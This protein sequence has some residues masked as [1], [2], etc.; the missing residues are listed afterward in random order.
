MNGF[1]ESSVIQSEKPV[2]LIPKCGSCG[3]FKTC[4]SPKMAVAGNGARKVLVV[5]EAPGATEDEEGVPFVG[6]AGQ[7][8]RNALGQ[9]GVRLER[10]AWV[11]NALICRPPENKTPDVKQISWCRPNILQTINTYNPRVVLL[12]GRS[13][14]TSVIEPYWRGDIGSMERWV[15]WRIPLEKHWV[16]PTYHPSFLLRMDNSLLN[17]LFL[18][19]LERAFEIDRDPPKQPKWPEKIEILFE[20]E[21]IL[22]AI[23]EIDREGGPVAVDY[24]GNCLKPEYPKAKAY[25]FSISNGT[26]TISYPWWGK[27]IRA[28]GEFLASDRTYKI[29]SNMKMEERWTR[30]LF[31]HGVRN[32]YWDTMLAAHCLDNREAITSIK[33]QAFIHLGVPAYNRHVE[34]FL[35]STDGPYNRIFEADPK[36]ILFYGGMDSILEWRM[37]RKQRKE[38]GYED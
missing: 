33:F 11:T 24:E 27:A 31:G 29:A 15:G 18:E 30:K 13:A 26:R 3:L 6:K 19:H 21:A 25:S 28:T 20:E 8:L 9:I 2:G 4:R 7:Y 10:D 22:K 16:V 37:A 12:L 1:F 32:W 5:G 34:P 17:R 14:L 23:Y 38:M 36:M 35:E